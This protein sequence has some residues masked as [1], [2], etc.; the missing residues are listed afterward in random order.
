VTPRFSIVLLSEDKSDQSW[1]GLR[2]I[3]LRLLR[4]FEDDGFTPRVV[5]LPRDERAHTMVIGNRWRSTNP[6][7]ETHVRDLLG[8]LARK[9]EEPSSFVVFHYDGDA[10]WAD[11]RRSQARDQFAR[12]RNRVHQTLAGSKRLSPQEVERRMERLIECVP[13]YSV[14]AWT[15]QATARAVA[16]CH[17][18]HRGA[19]AD[20]FARWGADRT[21]LDD[22]DKPKDSTC[23][24]DAHNAELGAHVPVEEVVQAGRSLAEFVRALRACGDLSDALPA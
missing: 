11:R 16:L 3:V 13:F 21:R 23:L 19:D 2:A 9:L 5:L 24:R 14:E 12:F 18:R 1:R 17:E 22:V 6:R 8:Y 15:Y 7:D 20:T 4:P 10:R